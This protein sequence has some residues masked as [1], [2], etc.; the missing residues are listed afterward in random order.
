MNNKLKRLLD[1]NNSASA[2]SSLT[3]IAIGLLAGFIV[4][5]VTNPAQALPGFAAIL[6]GGFGDLKSLGQ[7]LYFATPIIMTGLSVA[8]ASKTGLFN[9]GASGQFIVGAYSAIFVGVKLSFL[10]APFHWIAALLAAAIA[11]AVW[12]AIPGALKAFRNVNEVISCI[13]LNYIGM[14]LVNWLITKTIFDSLKNQSLRVADSANMPKMFMDKIFRDGANISSANSGIIVAIIMAVVIYII[15][16]KTKF[17]FELKACGFNKDASRY[18]G[19]NEKRSIIM[20]MV[21]A[22]AMAGLGGALLYLAGSG[23]GIDVIDVLAAEGFNGI[24][25]AL[26]ALNNPIGVI[27]SGLFVAYLNVGG[28]NMQLY[29][30]APQVI[31]IIIAIIIYFS[32]FSLVL[33]GIIKAL[34]ERKKG[35]GGGQT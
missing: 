14:Y 2:L 18:A 19:M 25:V 28:F 35:K 3:A 17:G 23:K 34:A 9:I 11:G 16:Q 10:P 13:M 12:G 22:G 29:S 5:L 20:S 30:F 4:L 33:R 6:T 24:P 21:I 15:L 8:F 26:L 27:F 32:A 31:E 7:V 1:I